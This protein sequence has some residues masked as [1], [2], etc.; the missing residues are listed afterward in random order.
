MVPGRSPRLLADVAEARG[1]HIDDARAGMTG[2]SA[3]A[4]AMHEFAYDQAGAIPPWGEGAVSRSAIAKHARALATTGGPRRLE[5][6]HSKYTDLSKC[7]SSDYELVPSTDQV[8]ASF[9]IGFR[10]K[11]IGV[12]MLNAIVLRYQVDAHI[13]VCIGDL[14]VIGSVTPQITLLVSIEMGYFGSYLRC[15]VLTEFI[16]LD[17][18]LYPEVSLGFK[19]GMSMCLVMSAELQ[20][21][22][23]RFWAELSIKACFEICTFCL[24]ASVTAAITDARVL[25][26]GSKCF[27]VFGEEICIKFPCTPRV[28]SAWSRVPHFGTLP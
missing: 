2:I 24:R 13:D 20:P 1:T 28:L 27:S 22:S 23:I 6:L 5:T 7:I 17:L 18:I 14:V 10:V 3:A 8:L 19:N 11:G 12:G 26:A 4:A 9:D 25:C 15:G 21:V 16:L